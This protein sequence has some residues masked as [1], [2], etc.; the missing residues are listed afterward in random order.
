[1]LLRIDIT[2][3]AGEITGRQKVQEDISFTGLEA[4][5][6]GIAHDGG[7][8]RL[9]LK[10]GGTNQFFSVQILLQRVLGQR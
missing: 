10:Q 8:I 2:V 7:P 6:L 5:R 4:D 1:M 3:T 9:F